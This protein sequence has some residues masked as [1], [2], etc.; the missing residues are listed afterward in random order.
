MIICFVHN[1][2]V[3]YTAKEKVGRKCAPKFSFSLTQCCTLISVNK[4][5]TKKN[6]D[7]QNINYVSERLVFRR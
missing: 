3:N 1:Q 7:K 6:G 5:E 2:K 4:K